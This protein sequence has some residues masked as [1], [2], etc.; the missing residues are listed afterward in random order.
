M[1]AIQLVRRE[2]EEQVSHVE[3]GDLSPVVYWPIQLWKGKV[4]SDPTGILARFKRQFD[5]GLFTAEVV[6]KRIVGLCGKIE[7][8]LGEVRELL[9]ENKPAAALVKTRTAMNDAILAMHWNYGELPRSQN[10]TDSRLR[11]FFD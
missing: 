6:D 9:A 1:E 11:L 5:A 8:A 4:V 2:L 3:G 7:K 10:R